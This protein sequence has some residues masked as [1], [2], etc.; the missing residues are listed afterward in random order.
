MARKYKKRVLAD[1]GVSGRAKADDA[2]SLT[3]GKSTKMQC[4]KCGVLVFLLKGKSLN[5]NP[6]SD[7]CHQAHICEVK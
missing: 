1:C 2:M 4:S 5:L 6:G 7:G 3:Y